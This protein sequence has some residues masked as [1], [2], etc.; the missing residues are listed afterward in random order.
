MEQFKLEIYIPESHFKE[1]QRALQSVDAG[2]IGNYDCCL[3]YSR[4]IGTWRPLPGT[5]PLIGEEGVI[6]EEE[7]LTVEVTVTGSRLDETIVAIKEVH[8]Y[9]EPVINVIELY[10]TG[11]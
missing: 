9:E 7:E 6:S 10:R 3:S 2:H 11:L 4:V 5:D 1:L 8:P